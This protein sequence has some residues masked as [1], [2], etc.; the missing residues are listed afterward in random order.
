MPK[1]NAS[2]PAANRPP[3][4]ESEAEEANWLSSPEGMRFLMR[5]QREARKRGTI[6]IE[7]RSNEDFRKGMDLARSTGKSVKF[8]NGLDVTPTDPAK[9]REILNRVKAKSEMKMIALRLPVADIEAAKRLASKHGVGYRI[10]L[11]EIIHA[12]VQQAS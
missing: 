3:H 5:K 8:V 4:F 9:L 10:L 7:G 2:A 12:A 6:R 1:K 11:K